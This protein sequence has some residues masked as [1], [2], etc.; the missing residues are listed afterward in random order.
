MALLAP[1]GYYPT[2]MRRTALRGELV[3]PPP[4]PAPQPATPKPIGD[5]TPGH[6][7]GV[8][9]QESEAQ[10]GHWARAVERLA[11]GPNPPDAAVEQAAGVGEDPKL[12]RE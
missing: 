10:V 6:V 8:A 3:Q 5:P 12:G 7:A 2:T 1:E 4:L 9:D 11:Y